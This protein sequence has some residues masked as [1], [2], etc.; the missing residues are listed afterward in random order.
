M[1]ERDNIIRAVDLICDD[2]ILL[3]EN[4]IGTRINEEILYSIDSVNSLLSPHDVH[5]F[6]DVII[7][8][9]KLDSEEFLNLNIIDLPIQYLACFILLNTEII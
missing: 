8:K 9:Y 2:I 6:I 5:I 4:T 1:I 3:I 7:D